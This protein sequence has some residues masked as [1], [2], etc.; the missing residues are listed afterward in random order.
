MPTTEEEEEE[1]EKEDV[2]LP[3]EETLEEEEEEKEHEQQQRE[4]KLITRERERY[5]SLL[6]KSA[7]K[8]K[9]EKIS[10]KKEKKLPFFHVFS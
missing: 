7:A 4:A 10:R 6:V 5:L 1:E 8:A 3:L 9:N 2:F